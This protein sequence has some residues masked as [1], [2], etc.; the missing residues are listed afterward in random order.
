MNEEFPD[1]L[2]P[3][4]IPREKGLYLKSDCLKAACVFRRWKNLLFMVML[5]SLL[6]HQASFWL[7][8]TGQVEITENTNT[9]TPVILDADSIQ[10]DRATAQAEESRNFTLFGFDVTFEHLTSLLRLTN[11]ILVF[12]SLLYALIMY[13]G[14]GISFKG[15]LGGL[16]HIC[17]AL[18]LSLIILVLLLPWQNFFGPIALGATFTPSEL[19]RWCTTDISDTFGMV[20]FY[21]RFTGYW[22]LVL[23]LLLLAQLRSFRWARAIHR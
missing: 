19:V 16:A 5:L 4:P 14:L 3:I 8:S 20:V 13:F 18:Y 15:G 1:P 11:I 2:S 21:L 10:T 22:A 23:L 7:V 12:A 9:E 6:L 17:G